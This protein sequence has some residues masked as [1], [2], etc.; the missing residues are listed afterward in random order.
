MHYK[1]E[2]I[3]LRR[4]RGGGGGG[5]GGGGGGGGKG[6]VFI[7]SKVLEIGQ[8]NNQNFHEESKQQCN[9][10]STNKK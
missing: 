1:A 3:G 8:K 9:Q 10:N 2:L 6:I 4:R 5:E 7:I